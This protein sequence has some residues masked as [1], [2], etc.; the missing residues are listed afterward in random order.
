LSLVLSLG[1]NLGSPIDN[2]KTCK[3]K[4][5]DFFTEI[6]SSQVYESTPTDFYDQP[7]FCNQLIEY[8]IPKIEYLACLDILQNIEIEMK[9]KKEIPKGPRLIDIDIIF[10]GRETYFDD[11]LVIPHPRWKNRSFIVIPLMELPFYTNFKDFIKFDLISLESKIKPLSKKINYPML[12]DGHI[13][14]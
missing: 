12:V 11:N 8:E 2:L 10:W 7:N 5:S 14:T 4:L 6:A 13:M 9:R 3:G 1:S